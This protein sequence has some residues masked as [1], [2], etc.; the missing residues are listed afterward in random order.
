MLIKNSGST[1]GMGHKNALCG[2]SLLYSPIPPVILLSPGPRWKHAIISAGY[3][4]CVYLFGGHDACSCNP[5][6]C[7]M[8]VSTNIISNVFRSDNLL[9][10]PIRAFW[11]WP[12]MPNSHCWDDG[13]LTVACGTANTFA[14]F[15]VTIIPI[16]L[17]ARLELPRRRRVG[18]IML[19]GTGFIVCAAGAARAYYTWQ[20]LIS[21]YDET[22]E[23][24][25][26]FMSATVEI[27][28]GV[29]SCE[30]RFSCLHTPRC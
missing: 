16:P 7:P 14:D 15:L 27:D 18:A 30:N 6:T 26:M 12:Q 17:I 19:I 5:D 3:P 13:L 11:V 21:S 10:S 20:S 9:F 25:G 23:S 1:I 4:D 29:V 24:Y 2:C 22:W 8:R 28:L